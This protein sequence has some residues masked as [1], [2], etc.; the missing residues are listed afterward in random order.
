MD[1]RYCVRCKKSFSRVDFYEHYKNCKGL[2]KV[3]DNEVEVV[4][5]NEKTDKDILVEKV[6]E[7]GLIAE[8][9]AKRMSEKKLKQLLKEN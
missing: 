7:R 9:T 6:V 2:I 1:K 8:S 3:E 4:E 5:D